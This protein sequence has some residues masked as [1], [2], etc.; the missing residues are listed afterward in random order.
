MVDGKW[1]HCQD[2]AYF[3]SPAQAPLSNEEAACEQP[4]L[5]RFHLVV[6]GASGCNAF[7]VRPRVTEEQPVGAAVT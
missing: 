1:G 3:G 4:D 2:C 7:E 5:R 6:F